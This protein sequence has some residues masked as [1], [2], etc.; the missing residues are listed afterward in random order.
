MFP[1]TNT[2][3]RRKKEAPKLSTDLAIGVAI[4]FNM[5]VL[6]IAKTTVGRH[7]KRRSILKIKIKKKFFIQ[8]L[9]QDLIKE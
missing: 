2:D 7:K 4:S 3:F 9:A 1:Q 6:H 5:L 8:A